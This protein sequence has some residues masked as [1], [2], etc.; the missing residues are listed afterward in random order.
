[1][2]NSP[3]VATLALLASWRFSPW[4]LWPA[5]FESGQQALCLGDYFFV[6]ADVAGGD[7]DEP[8]L[9]RCDERGLVIDDRDLV[10]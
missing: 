9:H 5:V 2:P 10:R 6:G 3:L 7:V 4:L 1:M 8:L